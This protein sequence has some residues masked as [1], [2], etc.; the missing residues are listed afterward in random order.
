MKKIIA[1]LMLLVVAFSVT[2]CKTGKNEPLQKEVERLEE[3]AEKK[4]KEAKKD[5]EAEK[6]DSQEEETE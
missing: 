4:E 2:G 5:K 1:I 3:K 6:E